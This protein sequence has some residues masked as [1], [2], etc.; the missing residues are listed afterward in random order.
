MSPDGTVLL[1]DGTM[2][3]VSALLAA[4]VYSWW[5]LLAALAGLDLL[6]SSITD[7]GPASL[8]FRRLGLASGCAIR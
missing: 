6:P 5:L 2:A 8:V 4:A 1:L 3:V 7:Y